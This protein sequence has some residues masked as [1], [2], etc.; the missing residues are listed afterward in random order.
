MTT[1]ETPRYNPYQERYDLGVLQE[2]DGKW[3]VTNGMQA[4]AWMAT[5]EQA[6]SRWARV[7]GAVNGHVHLWVGQGNDGNG[8]RQVQCQDCGDVAIVHDA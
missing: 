7:Y 1:T 3:R 6:R 2:E 8:Q 5:K 4:T